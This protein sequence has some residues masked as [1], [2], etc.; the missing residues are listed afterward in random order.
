MTA[1][2]TSATSQH[3]SLP[4]F[5]LPVN[6]K[7]NTG[8][9]RYLHLVYPSAV[10]NWHVDAMTVRERNML[11]AMNQLTDKKEWE[12]KVFDEAIVGKWRE[13]VLCAPKELSSWSRHTYTDEQGFS[14]EMFDFVRYNALL[15]AIDI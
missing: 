3:I 8:E 11:K 4:G 5:G 6:F 7:L 15:E 9:D 14:E 1:P 10:L 2:T 12:L 13:E